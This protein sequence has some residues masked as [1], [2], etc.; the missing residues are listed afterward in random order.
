MVIEKFTD[1]SERNLE[2]L[3]RSFQDQNPHSG[4]SLIQGHLLSIG[5]QVQRKRVREVLRRLDPILRTNRWQ[6][7]IRRRA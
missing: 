5:V 4:E 6:E 1:I 3:V 7:V 2:E